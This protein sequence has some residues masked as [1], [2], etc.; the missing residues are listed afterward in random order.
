MLT[1]SVVA[2]LLGCPAAED[3]KPA[4]DEVSLIGELRFEERDSYTVTAGGLVSLAVRLVDTYGEPIADQRVEFGLTGSPEGASLEAAG[5][6]T[7]AD[8]IA[9]TVLYAGRASTLFRVRA[10]A[11]GITPIHFSVTVV[12]APPLS[13]SIGIEYGGKRAITS[14]TVVIV[15]GMS[16]DQLRSNPSDVRMS[17]SV[18][19]EDPP[20]TF[21]P[22]AGRSYAIAAWGSDDSN[23]KLAW[24][25]KAYSAPLSDEEPSE[26]PT[27]TLEDIPFTAMA[28]IP[29]SFTLNLKP[30]LAGLAP[31]ARSA[32][33]A[34]LPATNTPQ[35]SFLLD[36][37]QAK[38]M[39][40]AAARRSDNLDAALQQLLDAASAGPLRFADALASEVSKDGSMC[41]LQGALTPVDERNMMLS[42]LTLS[43]PVYALPSD[44]LAKD[45]SLSEVE[46]KGVVDFDASYVQEEAAVK[47]RALKIGLGFGSYATYLSRLVEQQ[48]RHAGRMGCAELQNLVMQR[49]NSFAGL[50]PADAGMEC[51]RGFEALFTSIR[52]LWTAL[53]PQRNTISFAAGTLSAHDRDGDKSI[54]DL[55][56]AKLTGTWATAANAGIGSETALEINVRMAPAA[57][58]VR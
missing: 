1:A 17:R 10:S 21:N 13:L 42:S 46:L 35:A 34:A 43:P 38:W 55:G 4:T 45:L 14:N 39:N 18:P 54:D 56:P 51:T 57:V 8:G 3:D 24:G 9:T 20:L 58:N 12:A 37:I 52:E 49:P 6:M 50:S 30:L 15:E 41:M 5:A 27:V 40:I 23:S 7:D 29:L 32:V 53:D 44:S 28:P 33:T 2:C 31:L 16:C 48:E 26:P 19:I 36:L 25:C 47:V 11:E 22:G